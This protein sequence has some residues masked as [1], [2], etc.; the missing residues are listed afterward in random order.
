M[1]WV[2]V[3]SGAL[4]LSVG[5]AS[6]GPS[7]DCNQEK[8]RDLSIRGCSILIREN[9]R[10]AD[11][12]F[13]QGI[14]YRNKD[15]HDRAIADYNKAIEIDP[16][17]AA[18]YRSRGNAYADKGEYD[19]AIMDYTKAI[20]IDPKYASAYDNRCDAYLHKGE[21]DRAIV[22]CN[23]TIEINPKRADATATAAPP[24]GGKANMIG[25]LAT[26]RRP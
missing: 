20:E 19:R 18:A 8:D 1:M 12:Y 15:E 21:Y 7:E 10:N 17:L 5:T 25:Q 9:S 24:T 16:K 4:F 14:A 2:I 23:K 13:S 11:A 26:I 22:D 6:A 3:F